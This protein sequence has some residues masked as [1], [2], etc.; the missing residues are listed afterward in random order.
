MILSDIRPLGILMERFMAPIFRLRITRAT[1]SLA[2]LSPKGKCQEYW[3]PITDTVSPLISTA[4]DK[5]SGAYV[6]FMERKGR[7]DKNYMVLVRDDS[8]CDH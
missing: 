1:N 3:R 7:A 8:A 4:F 5:K 2:K 6:R